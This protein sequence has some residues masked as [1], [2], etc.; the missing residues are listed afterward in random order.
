MARRQTILMGFASIVALAAASMC[1][2]CLRDTMFSAHF[3]ELPNAGLIQLALLI[4]AVAGIL[5][6]AAAWLIA[7]R[8]RGTAGG[9]LALAAIVPPVLA[10]GWYVTNL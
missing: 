9:M 6:V 8:G 2:F 3:G 10:C 4:G 1:A 5:L 7:L